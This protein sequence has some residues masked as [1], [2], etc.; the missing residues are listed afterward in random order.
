M[1][2]TA[3][4][5][6]VAGAGHVFVAPEGTPIVQRPCCSRPHRGWTWGMSP[7]MV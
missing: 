6:R 5:V 2:L 1:A 3:Q 7:L 4:E